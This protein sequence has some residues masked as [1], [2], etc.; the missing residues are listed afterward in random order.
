MLTSTSPTWGSSV[1]RHSFH[2]FDGDL[3][4]DSA[5][6]IRE[7]WTW[8]FRACTEDPSVMSA[9]RYGGFGSIEKPTVARPYRNHQTSDFRLKLTVD[10]VNFL[11]KV[12]RTGAY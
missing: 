10:G 8:K 2:K 9:I 12:K 4:I 6:R 1:V 11:T 3:V 7:V 5:L